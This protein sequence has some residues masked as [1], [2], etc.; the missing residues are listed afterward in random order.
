MS[1]SKSGGADVAARPGIGG[2]ASIHTD[3][4]HALRQVPILQ[5]CL[6]LV[7]EGAKE[8]EGAAGSA[9]VPAG[10]MVALPAGIAATLR[11]DADPASGHYRARVL[12]FDA[13]LIAA[14]PD[15]THRPAVSGDPWQILRPSPALLEAFDHASR[16]V[17]S[18]HL[19][20]ALA[21]H[22]FQEVLLG[23][24]EQGV[25]WSSRDSDTLTQRLRLL[26]AGRPDAPWAAADAA[27]AANVS[28]PTLRRRL[29][30]EGTSFRELLAEVRLSHGLMLLQTS[31]AGIAEIALACGYESPSRFASRFR[32]RFGTPPSGI[33]TAPAAEVSETG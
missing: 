10:A 18:P 23:L 31:R 3:L 2:V 19:S 5:H 27:K 20:D 4:G 17:H 6:I 7:V 13:G 22:R 11:N 1:R 8:L 12:A 14:F 33:R 25:V 32:E 28:E 29:A 16:A 21:R 30:A 9:R 26:M 15:T 24:A